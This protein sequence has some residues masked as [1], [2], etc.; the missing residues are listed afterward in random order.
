MLT[1]LRNQSPYTVIL[2]F[3]FA[4]LLKL[5]ALLHPAMPHLIPAGLAYNSIV[6]G[7][8]YVLGS[9]GFGFTMLTAIM[10]FLQAMYLN[11]IAA[12]YK[13]FF[14]PSYVP[15]YTYLVLASIYQPFNYFS[16][17]L[18]NNWCLLGAFHILM[19]FGQTLQPRKHIF[20]AGFI[21]SLAV[22]LQFSAIGYLLLLLLCLVILRPF[23]I[24]EWIVGLMGYVTPVYFFAAILFLCDRLPYMYHWPHL[25]FALPHI[26][27][28]LYPVG[29]LGGVGVLVLCGV[30]AMQKL[31]P[32][33][34]IYVRR[35]WVAII[36]CLMISVCIAVCTPDIPEVW[37]ITL[38][39]LCLMTSNA[40]SL[41]KSKRFSN[42]AFYFS[43]V[44]VIFAQVA[45]NK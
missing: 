32:K 7:A 20:N 29:I 36:L 27:K 43:L 40:F 6:H 13:L 22:L 34:S 38:P 21:L 45:L 39:A 3:I 2:L 19:G 25:G 9:S 4:L 11:H 35:N 26:E 42:F 10:V 5:Q 30:F 18:L 31:L 17:P 14:R 37:F 33:G 28:H 8:T 16:E 12:R 23:N 15:A 41:E 1:F 24:T 44:L